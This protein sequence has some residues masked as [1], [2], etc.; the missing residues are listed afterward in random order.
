MPNKPDNSAD[1]LPTLS[2]QTRDRLKAIIG[3]KKT[4]ALA[5]A[6]MH[7]T[8]QP[9]CAP[10]SF[11]QERLW[12]QSQLE[13]DNIAYNRPFG[14][15]LTGA[16]DVGV[17]ARALSEIV[18]RH[19]ILR[20]RYP[21]Q[22]GRPAQ[23]VER[24]ERVQL[25]AIDL[26]NEE[27]QQDQITRGIRAKIAQSFD[28][29]SGP[30]LRAALWQIQDR[31][32]LLLITIHHI[33]FDGWSETVLINELAALYEAFHAGLPSPLSALPIQYTQYAIEQR[34]REQGER[35][36]AQL[37]YWK[38]QLAGDI[39]ILELPTDRPR[40]SVQTSRGARC[41]VVLSRELSDA[42][43]TLGR[44]Q[45]AT[46]FMVLLGAFQ[47]LL[48]RY[49]RQ[50]DVIVGT[51]IAG[52]SLLTT[53][54]L[55]GFFI[56]TL[57][58]KT[59]LSGDPTFLELLVR[60]RETSL[61][62]YANQDLSITMLVEELRPI[63]DASRSPL[64][65]VM[66]VLKG[67]PTPVVETPALTFTPTEIDAGTSKFDVALE[68]WQKPDGL[69]GY[70]EYNPDLF[71]AATITRLLGHYEMLLEGISTDPNQR[72]AGLPLMSEQECKL[73][74]TDWNNTRQDYPSG[75]C[76]HELF[77]AQ[78][79]STPNAIALVFKD[80]E[81]SYA[82]LNAKANRLAHQLVSLGVGPEVL[83][84]VC[85]ERSIEMVVALLA[86][87]K[88]G[89]AY[90]PLD[91]DYPKERLSF[92]LKDS[93]AAAVV[94]QKH[95]EGRLP[96]HRARRVYIDTLDC[97][98]YPDSD[99]IAQPHH[100]AYVIYTSGS[101]G[102]PKGVMIEHRCLVN[103][104][105]AAA[106]LYRLQPEDRILQFASISFD[107][108]VREIF[109]SLTSGATLVLC[110]D[111]RMDAER[112]FSSCRGWRITLLSLPTAYWHGLANAIDSEGL[113]VEQSLRLI[114]AGGEKMLADRL[115]VWRRAAPHLRLINSYGPTE[116]TVSAT[117]WEAPHDCEMPAPIPIGRPLANTTV[118]ILDLYLNPVP[119]GVP[120]EIHIGGAGLARG[121]LNRPELTTQKFIR[122]P[123][124]DD[125]E[126]RLY[127]TGDL[128]RYLGDGNIEFLGRIDTQVK[129]RG[130]RIELGEIEAVL[131]QHRAVGEA[132]VI[133]TDTA[134]G[135]KRL[136]AYVVNHEDASPSELHS[137]LKDKL[138]EYM[139]PSAIVVLAS[140]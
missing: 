31:E 90:L 132:V 115:A 91:P 130:F 56:N 19:E 48:H 43:A 73:V 100:L 8:E 134:R 126:A 47:A 2:P 1:K 9:Q 128:A 94:T 11:A 14:V 51:P 84:G 81:L 93:Q 30:V 5:D 71:D 82:E 107:V 63:R 25:T 138:P 29:A 39:P 67:A 92:M 104:I 113:Q 88:A 22:D 21:A 118:Y 24:P 97:D 137:F 65:Q 77:E 3:R 98:T 59:D 95:L 136:V 64:H 78:V 35:L 120:G 102:R 27:K 111:P 116:T 18:S 86:I 123:F 42:L 99:A 7:A 103:Y 124:S 119:I 41:A 72:I 96:Q 4:R 62:A 58:L 122:N 26:R 40:P 79:E 69:C 121:Y 110:P 125:P 46:L 75:K 38:R 36:Q 60:V 17:L 129:I 34:K 139:L 76:V 133:A 61:A 16:L 37:A 83:A 44:Q 10:L 89:G 50:S 106:R 70:I 108:S 109:M 49:T 127:K 85:L 53:E 80:E 131:M 33:A 87:L 140:D 135:D 54:R 23:V 28:L 68:L 12:F 32:H 74:L 55:I 6:K 57:I 15:L 105:E 13:P 114:S 52:R 20:T 45:R 66:F 112:F 101:T 117:A